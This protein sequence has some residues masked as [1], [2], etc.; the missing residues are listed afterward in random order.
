MNTNH[1]FS[2]IVSHYE[3][4]LRLFGDSHLGVDWRDAEDANRRY[5]IMLDIIKNRNIEKNNLLDFGC[6]TAALLDYINNKN[7]N[8]I[9]YTGLDVSQDFIDV[10]NKKYPNTCF[11]KINILEESASIP[12]FDYIVMN[13][14]FT[15]KMELSHKQM[16]E[17]FCSM[18]EKV[19]SYCKKGIAFNLR[20]KQVEFEDVE[21][22][23]L[24]LDELSWFLVRK[25]GRKFIIRN[26]YEIEEYTVYLYSDTL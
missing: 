7:L 26:D 10:C 8:Y 11:L 5:G 23:H 15:E 22:F 24:S 6:G 20:S 19:F 18:I 3:N 12:S 17:Y 1:P 25:F 2:S 4:C 13:G 16:F 21:L 14:V 9:N